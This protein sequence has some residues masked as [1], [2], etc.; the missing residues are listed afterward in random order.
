[1]TRHKDDQK[2]L[3]D[4]LGTDTEKNLIGNLKT[5]NLISRLQL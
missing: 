1:M 5:V 3:Y 4:I 2:A